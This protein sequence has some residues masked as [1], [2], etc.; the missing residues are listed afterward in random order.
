MERG[1]LGARHDPEP[2]GATDTRLDGVS[3]VTDWQCVATGSATTT[4]TSPFV[5]SAPIARSGYRFVASDGG[6]FSYGN[7]APFLGSMGG[8]PLNQPIVGMAVMP[9]G[10]GYYLVAA[11]GGIFSFGSARST[12]RQ[13][14]RT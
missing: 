14:A 13:A 12:A 8:T 1:G 7:G 5:V 6:V 4:V 11:D 3:C 10:D 2:T 9:A